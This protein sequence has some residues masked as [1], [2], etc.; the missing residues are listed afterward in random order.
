LS[1]ASLSVADGSLSVSGSGTSLTLSGALSLGIAG[2]TSFVNEML[3][4][5]STE[6][7]LS[8]ASGASVSVAGAITTEYSYYYTS[9]SISGTGSSLTVGGTLTLDNEL[10]AESGGTVRLG[11]LL[12]S[13]AYAEVYVDS[14]SSVE[15]G[16]AGNAATGAI[17][18]DAGKHGGRHRQ[19]GA[20]RR[21]R[22]QRHDFRDRR[23]DATPT[24]CSL[25]IP[26]HP[27]AA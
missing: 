8:I 20:V 19:C 9:I 14:A 16:S 24:A 7:S 26:G 15:I 1:A 13:N 4:Y 10:N 22:R 11:G 18:V 5:D 12:L 21:H 27:A 17:T 6:G 25:P 2:S 23:R 3:Y